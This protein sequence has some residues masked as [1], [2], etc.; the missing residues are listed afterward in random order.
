MAPFLSE[1]AAVLHVLRCLCAMSG[2]WYLVK[3]LSSASIPQDLNFVFQKDKSQLHTP[4]GWAPEP[5]G[6]Y[7]KVEI[8]DPAGT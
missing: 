7:G 8:L 2:I 4:A 6:Q 5:T 1:C 3:Q